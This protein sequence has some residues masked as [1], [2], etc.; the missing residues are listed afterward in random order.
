MIVAIHVEKGKCERGADARY[1][2]NVYHKM[3][4][5]KWR[6]VTHFVFC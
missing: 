2:N 1:N 3:N 6:F 5:K 4:Y